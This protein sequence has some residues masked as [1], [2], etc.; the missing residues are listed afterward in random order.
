LT[1]HGPRGLAALLAVFAL[2]AVAGPASSAQAAEFEIVPDSFVVRMLNAEGQAENRAGSHPDRLDISFA[3]HAEGTTARDLIFE[4]PPGFG[5][6][7][8]AAQQ[9]PRELFEAGEEDCPPESQVGTLSFMLSEGGEAELPIFQLEPG[10]G[11]FLSFASTAG[12][13]TPL[14]TELRPDDFGITMKAEDLPEQALSEGRMELWGV[15]A[16]HQVGTA[17]PRR[18]LLTT[19]TRCGPLSFTFRTR[20]WLEEAPWLSASSDTGAPLQGCADLNFQPKLTMGL[21]N[22]VADSP[23]GVRM[24]VTAPEEAEGSE[25]A[26]ALIKDVTI[27]LPDGVT[28]SP[29]GAAGLT[30]C[31]DA[32]LEL[33]STGEARCPPGSKVGAVELASPVISDPLVGAVY[34]AEERPPE[35]FR[36]FVV[37]PG[38]GVVVK[39][40]GALHVDPATGRFS[41]TLANLPQFPLRRLSLSFDG[42]P[43]ALLASPLACGPAPAVGAFVSYGGGAP[44]ES[45]A[46]VQIGANIS[47]SL[48]PGAPPFAPR[49]VTRNSQTAIGRQTALSVSLL[50]RDGEQVPRRFAL[51][52]PAGLSAALGNV[53]ACPDAGVAA[54]AC[55]AASRIGG[56]VARMGPGPNPAV[57]RGDAY[58]TGP[59]RR[60]PFGMLL[61]LPAAV[62]SLN[63]GT[64]S[65][66]AGATIDARTGRVS[67]STD[68][69]PTQIEGIPLRFQA[70]ELSIDRPGLV[71]NPTSCRP[72][73]VDATVEASS[74]SLA[75][76]AGPLAL[77]GCHRLGFR[78]RLQVAFEGRAELHRHGHPGLRISAHARAG[79]TALRAMKI[80]L[81]GGLKFS[82]SG[83]EQICSRPDAA[84]GTC[85]AGARA[86][87]AV[88][89][90]PLLSKPL[91]G[92]IYIVQPR[93]NGLPDLGVSLA[94]LGTH[95]SFSGQTESEDGHL[96]TKLVGLPDMPLSSFTMRLSGGSDGSLSL[97][98]GLCKSGRPRRLDSLLLA[99]GQ[100][101]SKRRSR[102]P[103]ET[104]ARC[105]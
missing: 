1:D 5:G 56:V 91:K 42:G 96:I 52:L 80:S 32:E 23:T 61:Q 55:P 45:R 60:A 10:P 38:P 100:D 46:S 75:T 50:R 69:L 6:S 82:L 25:L 74:G 72:A 65:F 28:V 59:Y 29:S 70:I 34:L 99:T 93:D 2:V 14:K 76:A 16:D 4:L 102:A 53:Q 79:D 92:A 105:R 87:T 64:T 17:I 15:P 85:P 73:A 98:T 77:S 101:G 57:L 19:P 86:G 31:T 20:S 12:L 88:A 84:A 26:E 81:P 33:G 54:G 83:L 3:L 24:G 90:T 37:A 22:P 40:V 94:A 66:R 58:V 95:L 43:G 104:H 8:D 68:S 30:A 71:H 89:R 9:C 63:L 67:V 78:P 47:G 97:E 44:V 103:I 49:L 62:G 7:P 18:P 39:F 35:R 48:C 36:F 41:T 27:Q 21:S 11:E 13:E 51:A